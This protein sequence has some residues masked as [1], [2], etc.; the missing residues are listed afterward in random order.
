MRPLRLEH[1]KELTKLRSLSLNG[2][3][4]TDVGLEHLKDLNRLGILR[5]DQT[6]VKG[7]G[8][9]NFKELADLRELSLSAADINDAGL[10]YVNNLTQLKSLV[11]LG[12]PDVTDAGLEHLKGLSNPGTLELTGYRATESGIKQLQKELPRCRISVCQPP[13][14]RDEQNT[15]PLMKTVDSNVTRQT[16]DAQEGS[17]LILS[18]PSRRKNNN[19]ISLGS[20]ANLDEFFPGQCKATSRTVP[21]DAA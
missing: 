4:V 5:L 3:Q 8:L 11:L 21:V 16:V 9:V 14:N 17:S 20:Y 15:A 10:Q 2:T 7:P 6:N 13:L 18:H 19:F 12:L 1:L